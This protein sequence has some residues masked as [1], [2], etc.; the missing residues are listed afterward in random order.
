[1]LPNLVAAV[2]L[3]F[4]TA[5][6][7]SARVVSPVMT[8]VTTHATLSDLL[9]TIARV[10]TLVCGVLI[11]SASAPRQDRHLAARR[12]R[13]SSASPSA[14]R[15]RTSPPTSCPGFIMG[16]APALREG[17]PRRHRRTVG[18]IE[19]IELRATLLTTLQGLSVI[20][21]NKDVVP[22]PI[23]N[24]TRTGDRRMDLLVGIEQ[25]APLER[26]PQ[27]LALDAAARS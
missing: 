15:S 16:P 10:P 7:T 4:A 27:R 24:Y 11:A 20:I 26:S 2:V 12:R 18:I 1:M 8:R 9:G 6:A 5:A 17:R 25:G 14:S 23:I 19:R 13:A 21:P 3:V 22:D